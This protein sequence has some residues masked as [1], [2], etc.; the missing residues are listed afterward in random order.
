[1]KSTTT[2]RLGGRAASVECGPREGGRS[3]LLRV[4]DEDGLVVG[5]VEVI[6]RAKGVAEVRT[7]DYWAQTSEAPMQ[8]L[9]EARGRQLRRHGIEPATF[10]GMDEGKLKV[11]T[12]A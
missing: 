7:S 2:M 11:R 12:P 10:V 3:A 9:A 4:L 5:T 6:V 1:M 8:R